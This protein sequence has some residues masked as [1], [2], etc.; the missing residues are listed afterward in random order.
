MTV[1]EFNITSDVTCGLTEEEMQKSTVKKHHSFSGHVK[2]LWTRHKGST[3]KSF[4]A[5][6]I[7]IPFNHYNIF[8]GKGHLKK[9][10]TVKA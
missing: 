8:F 3:N 5:E 9:K 4:E 7:G 10:K 2:K 1:P 6:V